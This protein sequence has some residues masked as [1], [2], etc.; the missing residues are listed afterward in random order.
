[1]APF[2]SVGE[3]DTT[4]ATFGS[5]T[6]A[7][8]SERGWRDAR[9]APEA[10]RKLTHLLAGDFLLYEVTADREMRVLRFPTRLTPAGACADRAFPRANGAT[11]S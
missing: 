2:V 4:T 11:P 10:R 8:H 3:V 5:D 7:D 6:M 9:G 1:V